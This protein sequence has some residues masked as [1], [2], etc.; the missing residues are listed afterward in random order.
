ML[1]RRMPGILPPMSQEE[2]LEVTRILSVAALLGERPG[3]V[4]HRP[5][6]SPH[7]NVSLAGLIGGGSGLARPGEVSLAHHGVLFLDELTL[8]RRDCLEALRGPLEDGAVRIARSGGAISY[9][10]RFSLIAAMNP[11]ACGY[12][13]DPRRACSC[14]PR[15]LEL[16]RAKLSGP[17]LDR[18]DLHVT[19]ARPE[20]RE[21]LGGPEGDA[22]ATVRRRVERARSLQAGRYSSQAVTNSSATKGMLERRLCPSEAARAVLE[23]AADA[24]ALSGRGIDRVLRVARTLADLEEAE[25]VAEEH[26]A[27]ALHYRAQPSDAGATA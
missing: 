11:C 19:M 16:Y 20:R 17:L 24:L 1:A 5:F 12:L 14:S 21:L 18:F 6:R 2:S 13:G 9:P 15:G 7:H 10:C 23:L 3:L 25:E 26:V 8:Y 22:S 27:E 4:R